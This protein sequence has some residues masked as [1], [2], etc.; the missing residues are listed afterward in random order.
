MADR[1]EAGRDFIGSNGILTIPA[2]TAEA[3]IA[4][5]TRTDAVVDPGERLL[6]AITGIEAPYPIA[7]PVNGPAPIAEI[8]IRDAGDGGPGS[9]AAPVI[10]RIQADADRKVLP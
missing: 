7:T 4:I 9:N 8:L 6:V 5:A 1:A 2:G 10:D 3:A